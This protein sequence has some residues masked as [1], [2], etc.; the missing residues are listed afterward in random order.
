MSAGLIYKITNTLNGKCYVGQTTRTPEERFVEHK[1]CQTSNI[2]REIR[3]YG[4]ENFTVEVLEECEIREL[5]NEREI[6]WIAEL[7]C[8]WPRGYNNAT[9]GQGNRERTP[10]SV[11]KMS[12]KGMHHSDASRKQIALSLTDDKNP[13][14]G[15]PLS[16][17]TKARLSAA[18]KNKR[19]VICV[20][21]GEVFESMTAAARAKQSKV[22]DI[23]RACNNPNRTAGGFHWRY[24][25]APL[26]SSGG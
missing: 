22:Q 26:L 17:E 16:D 5:L 7:D 3:K 8:M 2:G 19:Q 10:E 18:T 4:V 1:R 13:Q 14:Y 12:R 21:T 25:N 24:K 6:F 11:A 23:S 9:G 20:E 15:K